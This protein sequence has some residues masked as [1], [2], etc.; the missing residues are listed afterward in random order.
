[1]HEELVVAG[2]R[3]QRLAFSGVDALT[4]SERRVAELAVRGLRNREIAEALFVCLKTVEVH[5]GRA[6]TKLGIKGRAQLAEALNSLKADPC[7]G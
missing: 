2:A 5:L 7:R 1:M 3:P 4:A 6:Y